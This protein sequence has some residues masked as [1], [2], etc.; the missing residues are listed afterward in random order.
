M[1]VA[2]A[3]DASFL[4]G[5]AAYAA[6]DTSLAATEFRAALEGYRLAGRMPEHE[7]AS[8]KNLGVVLRLEGRTAE[9]EQML[10][11]ALALFAGHPIDRA[12][13]L[14]NLGDVLRQ[15]GATDAAGRAV[16]QAQRLFDDNGGTERD[17]AD[18]LLALAHVRAEQGRDGNDERSAEA[19]K[20]YLAALEIYDADPEDVPLLRR[21]RAICHSGLG[22]LHRAAGDLAAARAEHRHALEILA[23]DGP[24]HD[25]A[26]CEVNLGNVLL[27]AEQHAAAEAAYLRAIDGYR[28]AG[29]LQSIPAVQHNLALLKEAAASSAADPQRMLR[30]ALELAVASALDADA[31]RF[32]FAAEETRRT[33]AERIAAQRIALAFRLAARAGD[34]QTVSDL[35]AMSRAAGVLHLEEDDLLSAGALDVMLVGAAGDDDASNDDDGFIAGSGVS[36]ALGL[37]GIVRRRPLPPLRMPGGRMAF[38]REPDA[39]ESAVRFQ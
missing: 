15:R 16:L 3:A 35:I 37:D 28:A 1:T 14:L 25:I 30:Q 11:E 17:R 32:A 36:G 31:R 26:D 24:P 2:D 4:A 18:C 9:A 38:G 27:D 21:R 20:T 5:L 7:A 39:G 6:S 10:R 33:W 22:M 29:L 12:E 34:T 19:E 8:L 23:L 13:C